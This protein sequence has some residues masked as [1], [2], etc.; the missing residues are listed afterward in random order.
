MTDSPV[1]TDSPVA[2]ELPFPLS[3][4]VPVAERHGI[5]VNVEPEFRHAAQFLYP[6]GKVRCVR[7]KL[8]DLNLAASCA[9]AKGLAFFYRLVGEAGLPIPRGGLFLPAHG[10]TPFI[11]AHGPEVNP[12]YA[13]G[14]NFPFFVK[15]PFRSGRAWARQVTQQHEFHHVCLDAF[16]HFHSAYFQESVAGRQFG[17]VTL[18]GVVLAAYEVYPSSGGL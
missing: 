2:H 3:L 5:R 16:A 1:V 18:D 13:R 8:F 6:S 7:G 12:A 9:H 14:F 10:A 4:M 15:P 17:A 11:A